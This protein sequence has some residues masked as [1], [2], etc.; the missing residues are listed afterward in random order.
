MNGLDWRYLFRLAL[1]VVIL[2]AAL[3]KIAD[4]G[5]FAVDIHNYRLLPAVLENV[6]ALTL[7]WIELVAGV[8]LVLNLA[9][10]AGTL[11]AG[12]LMV[13]F[14]I[15]IGLAVA[16]NLDIEC[17]CFGTYDA[18][19]T[20][21]ATLLRDAGFLALAVLGWP[22]RRPSGRARVATV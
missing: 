4:P 13:V 14:L 22:R 1:G 3:P 12:G 17:G 15:A 5:S 16:R 20:G 2:A 19:R 9:P 11:V 18:S 7:P 8:A 6:A 21:W 10:K